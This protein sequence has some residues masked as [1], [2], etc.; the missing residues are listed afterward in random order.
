MSIIDVSNPA[1]LTPVGN[2]YFYWYA[3]DLQVVGTR[4]IGL[5]S[6]NSNEPQLRVWDVSTPSAPT[7]LGMADIWD[8][9]GRDVEVVGDY[10][11]TVCAPGGYSYGSEFEIWNVAGASDPTLV[12]SLHLDHDGYA[13]TVAGKYIFIGMNTSADAEILVVK[14]L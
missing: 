5:D 9:Y 11:L 2:G 10:A 6:N 12:T 7:M 14:A 3:Y 8:S 13:V 1:A 4:V